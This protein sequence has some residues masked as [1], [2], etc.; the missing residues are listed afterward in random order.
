MKRDLAERLAD[1]AANSGLVT[2]IA[3]P[4]S[5]FL[6]K[7]FQET[8]LR[9][10]K[11]L[12]NGTWLEHPLHPLLTDVPVG[13]WTL[14]LL[15]DLIA[16]V[17]GVQNLGLASGIAI[18]FG[19]LAALAAMATGFTDWMDVDPPEKALGMLHAI[20]NIIA[21][22]FFAI[23]FFMLW[24]SGWTISISNFIVALVGYLVITVGAYLGGDLVFRMGTMINRNAYRTGPKEFTPA[25]A[26]AELPENQL[27]RV[28]VKGQPILLSRRGN[29]IYAIGAV[30]SHYGG[31]LEKGKLIDNT[32]QCPFHYSRFSLED[33]SVREGPSTAPAPAY[34]TQVVNGTVQ[35]KMRK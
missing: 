10:L 30:C 7:L 6:N 18:G 25:I 13:T 23:A 12:A 35:V 20:V 9:P 3:N 31:P 32:V 11:L 34:E 1:V 26:L 2:G 22:V 5:D 29:K 15:L 4:L 33:G 16:L 28:E 24:S 8:P 21:T 19:V 27:K 14:A 17:L